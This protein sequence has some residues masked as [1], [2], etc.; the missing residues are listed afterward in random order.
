LW[1]LYGNHIV[2]HFLS[3]QIA[4]SPTHLTSL[5]DV[6]FTSMTSNFDQWTT[7][8]TRTSPVLTRRPGAPHDGTVDSSDSPTSTS[9]GLDEARILV[10][11]WARNS[12]G[13]SEN[14]SGR[15]RK[16][17]TFPAPD[18]SAQRLPLLPWLCTWR[19]S[20]K[21]KMS[22]VSLMFPGNPTTFGAMDS[23]DAASN[24]NITGPMKPQNICLGWVQEFRRNQRKPGGCQRNH[25][26]EYSRRAGLPNDVSFT[27]ADCAHGDSLRRRQECYEF[28]RFG[29]RTTVLYRMP[30]N[31]LI[32][33]D[34]M[35]LQHI[36]LW[37]GAN[38]WN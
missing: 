27:S 36:L 35:K 29:N 30:R 12:E 24:S 8:N 5:V 19:Q 15:Q 34:L 9:V 18:I 17:Q 21:D 7:Q 1:K 14:S 33:Q 32:S 25:R 22:R 10:F 26:T 16:L 2:F 3:L 11:G 38:P 13:N 4:P 31:R 28:R 37:L 20:T 6:S 23:S